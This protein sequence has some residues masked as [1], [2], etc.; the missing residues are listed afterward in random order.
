MAGVRHRKVKADDDGMRLDRWFRKY[1]PALTQGRLEKLL[2]QGLVRLDGKRAKA[3]DRVTAGQ[4]MRVPPEVPEANAPRPAPSVPDSLVA[5][6][7]E[8]VIH[9]DK[10][11]LVLNKPSGLAVQGQQNRAAC[12]CGAARPA[13]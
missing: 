12:R 10:H 3:A 11:V 2:R 8:A 9:R 5:Q 4:S 1:F 7:S 13:V 6:L